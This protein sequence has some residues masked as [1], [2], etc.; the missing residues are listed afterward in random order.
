M[1]AAC[2]G[3]EAKDDRGTANKG[4]SSSTAFVEAEH[5]CVRHFTLNPEE[6]SND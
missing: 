6:G 1:C 4:E 5:G 3:R 2:V